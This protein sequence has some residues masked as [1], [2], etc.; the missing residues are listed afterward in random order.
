MLLRRLFVT[1]LPAFISAAPSAPSSEAASVLKVRTKL[2]KVLEHASALPSDLTAEARHVDADAAVALRG[3]KKA[4][5][6]KVLSE[7]TAFTGHLTG[8]SDDLRRQAPPAMPA[9][10]LKK[11]AALLPS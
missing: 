9:E 1:L 4:D 8:K 10:A 2:A 11:A 7:F 6:E 3:S 5:L